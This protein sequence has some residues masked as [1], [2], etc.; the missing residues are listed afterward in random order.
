MFEFY[1]SIL[2]FIVNTQLLYVFVEVFNSIYLISDV[3]SCLMFLN[4]SETCLALFFWMLVLLLVV[5]VQQFIITIIRWLS[6][7]SEAFVCSL[8]ADSIVGT[9]NIKYNN[10][11]T[12]CINITI[13]HVLR[14][15]SCQYMT[16]MHNVITLLHNECRIHQH[17]RIIQ[18]YH[19]IVVLGILCSITITIVFMYLR[20]IYSGIMWPDNCD[21]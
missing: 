15:L 12:L 16:L 1:I 14:W 9:K 10:F 13:F 2:P 11:T 8:M 21:I 4:G 6:V 18:Q 17:Y 5:P 19:C 7:V 3:C 20:S